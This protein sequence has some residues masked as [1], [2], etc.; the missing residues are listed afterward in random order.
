MLQKIIIFEIILIVIRAEELCRLIHHELETM[1]HVTKEVKSG[2]DIKIFLKYRNA[3]VDEPYAIEFSCLKPAE[4]FYDLLPFLNVS[5]LESAENLAIKKCELPELYSMLE[6]KLPNVLCLRL[7]NTRL[8]QKFFDEKTKIEEINVNHRSFIEIKYFSFNRMPK[9]KSIFLS[10]FS[11][12]ITNGKLIQ[13]TNSLVL[14]KDEF[15]DNPHL[16]HVKIQY[17]YIQKLP[18]T[19]FGNS[20]DVQHIDFNNNDISHVPNNFF[21]KLIKLLSINLEHNN[22]A[23]INF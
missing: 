14:K 17:C 8:A 3:S 20:T 15:A 12:N 21:K 23:H 22:I 7:I 13:R 18:S 2:R 1:D 10:R 19:L 4:K 9:L 11:S 16:T 6:A 5:D